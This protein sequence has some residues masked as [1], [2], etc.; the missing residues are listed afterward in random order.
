MIYKKLKIGI[1]LDDVCNDY[2]EKYLP[3][4]SKK[5]NKTF[6]LEE[7]YKFDYKI[8]GLDDKTVRPIIDEFQKEGG[9]ADSNLRP[10]KGAFEAMKILV[11]KG[12]EL[13]IISN[14]PDYMQKST[15][16]FVETNFQGIFSDILLTNKYGPG[17][18][19]NSKSGICKDKEIDILIE[20]ALPTV[21]ECLPSLKSGKAIL[22]DSPWNQ[23]VSPKTVYRAHTWLKNLEGTPFVLD[24]VEKIVNSNGYSK[25]IKQSSKTLHHI[26][27]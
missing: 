24:S 26:V 3:F 23:R 16:K 21:K 27:S 15:E 25:K 9:M 7:M 18:P 13:Y 2:H 12:A 10:R 20:D 6:R 1:D 5:L 19:S 22:F 8:F 14:R 17:G 4:M 11:G